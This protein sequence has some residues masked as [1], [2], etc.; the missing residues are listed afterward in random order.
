MFET[1]RT[2][3]INLHHKLSGLL[4]PPPM[5]RAEKYG[6]SDDDS[7][8][9]PDFERIMLDDPKLLREFRLFAVREFTVER[10]L[11]FE[12]Y[13]R[14][15]AVAESA[16]Q[17]SAKATARSW[18]EQYK[19]IYFDFLRPNAEMALSDVEE[20]V[21]LVAR[22]EFR[23]E[24]F[25]TDVL[26]GSAEQIWGA[27]W[28]ETYPKFLIEWRKKVRADMGKQKKWGRRREGSRVGAA[29]LGIPI[30]GR[31]MSSAVLRKGSRVAASQGGAGPSPLG[32][33]FSR[34]T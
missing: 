32:S 33:G 1:W 29:A 12:R 26:D 8:E 13:R 19:K 2:D 4:K 21:L 20:R 15:R 9:C 27:I 5:R 11:F 23:A 18:R 16:E 22:K 10:I 31:K 30:P 7:P 25:G 3:K 14:A 34:A 17:S 24:T 28:R 6:V